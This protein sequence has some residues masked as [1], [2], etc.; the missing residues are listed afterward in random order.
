MDL[1]STA[2]RLLQLWPHRWRAAGISFRAEEA[3]QRVA[4]ECEAELLAFEAAVKVLS[5]MEQLAG[6]AIA[7]LAAGPDIIPKILSARMNAVR[8]T[9]SGPAVTGKHEAAA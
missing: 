8:E 9:A 2:A 6:S 5:Q 1:L 7:D 4:A 3:S